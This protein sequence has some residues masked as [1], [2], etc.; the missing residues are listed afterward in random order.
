MSDAPR[1]RA[2]SELGR[3]LLAVFSLA[4]MILLIH[5]VSLRG[6][7]LMDD[8][9]HLRQLR[10]A[11]WTLSDLTA[12]CRLELVGG[13]TE[14]WWMPD[15]TLRFF[16]PVAFGLMKLTYELTNWTPLA[17][18]AA[19]LI[20]HW[21]ACVL[22]FALL[23]RLGA[24]L[25]HAWMMT[26][27]FAIHPGHV[28]TVQWIA[29]QTEL[30]VTTFLLIGTLAF[31][32]FR[33]WPRLCDP[34]ASIPPVPGETSGNAV[35]RMTLGRWFAGGLCAVCYALALGCRENAIMFPLVLASMELVL[36][37]EK[38]RGGL[39]FYAL[40]IGV[41]VAYLALRTI[42]LG[43]AALPP[44]PYVIPPTDP[45]F[46]RFVFDKL[47]YYLIGEF[48]L[49]PCIPI[50]G[51][52]YF[53]GHP[54]AFYGMTAFTALL[55]LWNVVAFRRRAPGA[56]GVVWL[57]AFLA[58]LLPAFSSSHHLYLP[59][60]GS[61]IVAWLVLHEITRPRTQPLTAF[62]RFRA[63]S[64]HAAIGVGAL[65]FAAMSFFLPVL[66]VDTA[67][68]VEKIVTD[69]V[70]A[71]P[72]KLKSGD[73]I[74]IA[75]LPIIAHYLKL[76]IEERT[77]LRDLRVVP[78]TW[79]PRVLGMWGTEALSEYEWVDEK[80]IDIRISGDPWFAEIYG[81]LVDETLGREMPV[82]RDA[83]V[84]TKDFR[85]ELLEGD[86]DAITAL[87]FRFKESPLRDNAHLFFGTR[88]RWAYEVC[89]YTPPAASQPAP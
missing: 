57:V 64:A 68:R 56:L 24:R 62:A 52:P 75:N 35:D 17:M 51:I 79:A 72:R 84:E 36:P 32:A 77:G 9:A 13:I 39:W 54:I 85:V 81:M 47:C 78:L 70:C 18:H 89:E 58:P 10:E 66:A 76:M 61:T 86:R 71:S 88:A 80:T 41:A 29:C 28:N 46:V 65:G 30:M 44:K 73:T 8:W 3:S 50:G 60:V 15:C 63:R 67:H 49:V 38:R 2:A 34:V 87:R 12:A 59:G 74:Y 33:A 5:G 26:A 40:L 48:L 69:E 82:S 31:A 11:K 27:L 19:S 16:R 4:L 55:L 42:S 22:I 20:W 53:R 1:P 6:G 37:R 7:W 14:Y 83:P 43:G 21:L 25:L 45:T 23:R